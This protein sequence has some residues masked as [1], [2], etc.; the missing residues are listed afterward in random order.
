MLNQIFL[1]AQQTAPPGECSPP[2]TVHLTM[3]KLNE[4]FRALSAFL[5]DPAG[6]VTDAWATVKGAIDPKQADSKTLKN[7]VTTIDS[8]VSAVVYFLKAQADE[9]K[10]PELTADE[11][12]AAS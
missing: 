2:Q 9:P 4:F 5:A 8:A 10:Q 11:Q 3:R 12:K 1:H 7:A 6:H